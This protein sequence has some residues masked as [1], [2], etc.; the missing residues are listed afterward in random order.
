MKIPKLIKKLL[1]FRNTHLKEISAEELQVLES[2]IDL[3]IAQ[4][5]K[6]N[7]Q[8]ILEGG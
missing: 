7:I 6:N 4:H 2:T 5:L 8:R 1:A 3:L